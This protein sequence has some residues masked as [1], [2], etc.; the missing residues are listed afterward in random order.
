MSLSHYKPPFFSGLTGITPWEHDFQIEKKSL[1]IQVE[2]NP[3]EGF[4]KINQSINSCL[5]ITPFR[6]RKD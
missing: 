4:T 3:F 2:T 5:K 1:N 6:S